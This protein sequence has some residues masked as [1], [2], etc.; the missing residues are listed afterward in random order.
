MT[1]K[2]LHDVTYI[3]YV[4]LGDKKLEVKTEHTRNNEWNYFELDDEKIYDYDWY[5]YDVDGVYADLYY[6]HYEAVPCLVVV[7]NKRRN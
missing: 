2:Q 6:V 1:L 7:V 4:K 3:K 5:I